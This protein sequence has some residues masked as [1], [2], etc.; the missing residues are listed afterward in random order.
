MSQ[1]L[2]SDSANFFNMGS[3]PSEN[4]YGKV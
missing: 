3:L 4:T 2:I 1:D